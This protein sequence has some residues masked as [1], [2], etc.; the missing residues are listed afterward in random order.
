MTV[1]RTRRFEACDELQINEIYNRITGKSQKGQPRSLEQMRSIWNLAPG[2][3][4]DSWIIE[5]KDDRGWRIIGHHGLC[6]VRFTLGN[7]D[8]LCGKTINSFL[9]PEFRDQFLYLRFEQQC[10]READT[11]FDATYS[12]ANGTSRLRSPLG[13]KNSDKWIQLERGF[14]PLHLIHRTIAQ[15]VGR[16]SYRTRLRWSRALA[17]ISS[18]L[19]PRSPNEF[20]EYPAMHAASS[21]FFADF[22]TEARVSAGVAARRDAS[23]LNWRFWERPGFEGHTLTYTWPEGGRAFFIVATANPLIF[24]LVDFFIT[25][26]NAQRLDSLLD[27]L[28]VWCAQ[29]GAFAL[30]FMTTPEGLPPQLM[31]VFCRKMKPSTLQRFSPPMELPRRLS[32]LGKSRIG[33]LRGPWNTTECLLV[34]WS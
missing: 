15:V 13:Y 14:Q 29:Q 4:A 5:A 24:S 32:P 8:L 28:F 22:W 6:P 19:S 12:V 17:S 34:G 33:D 26:A 31:E 21:S 7:Q 27:A 20:T 9:L 16:Y 30:K 2:G 18:V 10:L 11:R 1:F 23:D 25:P 3:P